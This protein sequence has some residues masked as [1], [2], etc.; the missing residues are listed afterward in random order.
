MKRD[1]FRLGLDRQLALEDV[2]ATLELAEGGR[3]PTGRIEQPHEQAV[4]I[5]TQGVELEDALH[6]LDGASVVACVGALSRDTREGR[7]G[8][9]APAYA[10]ARQPLL[11]TFRGDADALEQVARKKRGD[12]FKRGGFGS[13]RV[14]PSTVACRSSIASSKED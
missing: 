12:G 9:L 6:R 13:S 5:L 8:E 14:T 3:P 7:N 10:L 1:G 4:A 11:E 2:A